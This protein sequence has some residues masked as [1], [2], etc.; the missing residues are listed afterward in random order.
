MTDS[1]MNKTVDP[2]GDPNAGDLLRRIQ[3]EG[4]AGSD[5]SV[6][7]RLVVVEA[8]MEARRSVNSIASLLRMSARNVRR[9]QAKIREANA[10]KPGPNF[11][12]EVAGNLMQ[13]ARL[14]V[15]LAHSALKSGR[16]DGDGK[17]ATPADQIACARTCW[18]IARE[19]V[20]ELRTLGYLPSAPLEIYG[21]LHVQ[22]DTPALTALA[23]EL[24]RLALIARSDP[25]RAGAQIAS[26]EG[27]RQEVRTIEVS[28]K[29]KALS[30]TLDK[31]EENDG[32][33]DP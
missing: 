1:P 23:R 3:V 4:L 2:E 15:E 17:A 22:D 6:P 24:E 31:K 33:E 29:V 21:E 18:T 14:N 27:L 8:L 30:A 32:T 28:E 13:E 16:K 11:A 19:L 26:I 20:S 9:D 25:E 7:E 5:L 12:A 10:L